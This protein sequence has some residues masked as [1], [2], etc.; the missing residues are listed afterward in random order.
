MAVRPAMRAGR[1]CGTTDVGMLHGRGGMVMVIGVGACRDGATGVSVAGVGVGLMLGANG[2]TDVHRLMVAGQ[3]AG[4]SRRV[5]P[6][7]H[8]AHRQHHQR[9]RHQQGQQAPHVR[10]HMSSG[11]KVAGIPTPVNV[12]ERSLFPG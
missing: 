9:N 8:A 10:F 5:R 4:P 12:T 1:H 3:V 11:R 2:V 6:C 7:G